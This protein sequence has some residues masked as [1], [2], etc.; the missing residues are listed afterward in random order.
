LA[1]R[2][3]SFART[4]ESLSA[5][6][7]PDE[8]RLYDLIWKRALASQMAPARFDQVGV[9]V[10]ADRYTLH[11]GAR[12]RIFDGYQ[13]LYVEGKDDEEDERLTILPD[14]QDGEAL[15]LIGLSSEQHFTQ[16]PPRFT[17]ATLIRALEERGI[18]RDTD[19]DRPLR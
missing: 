16:P 8:L 10:S 15:D 7:K 2:P 13:A 1:I 3:S 18:G 19:R 12:K 4:P 14:L 5:H 9:D 11:A 17:E 6:L